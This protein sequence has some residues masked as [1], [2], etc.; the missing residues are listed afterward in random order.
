[1]KHND[2]HAV[3]QAQAVAAAELAAYASMLPELADAAAKATQDIAY[4]KAVGRQ[5][6]E[7]KRRLKIEHPG[8]DWQTY[9][10]ERFGYGKERAD[11]LIRV[12]N[13]TLTVDA[14]RE[15]KRKYRRELKAQ[16]VSAGSLLF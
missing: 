4:W 7:A 8:A 11:E 5:L 16:H 1:M 6:A 9:V 13:G 3:A 12:A 14:T 10:R 2:D 15:R